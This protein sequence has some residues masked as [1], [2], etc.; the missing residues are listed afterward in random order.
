MKIEQLCMDNLREGVFCPN[1][2]CFADEWHGQ[3]EAWLDG[4]ILKG[5]IARDDD[6]EAIGFVLYYPIEKA[7]MEIGGE[8]LYMVQCIQVKPSH[9][10]GAVAKMLIESAIADA[11]SSGASGIVTEGV[12]EETLH[13]HVS[14]T[15]L[16]NLGLKRGES[17][18][19]ATLYY[20]VFN[21]ETKEPKYLPARFDPPS[22]ETKLRVDIMDCR[23]CYVGIHNRE[24]VMQAVERSKCENVEVVVHDQSTREAVIDKGFS[25][26]VFVDGKLTFFRGPIS[27]ADVMNAIDVADSAHRRAMDK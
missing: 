1:G 16:D 27:E 15:F 14:A 8:G 6:G 20:V 3:L 25:S 11:S 21:N 9:D 18:G 12:R 5:Q 4:G 7:P 13:G 24:T 19:F 17:R 26:G 22:E 2:T 10:K 23:L